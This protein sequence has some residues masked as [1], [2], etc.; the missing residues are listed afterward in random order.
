MDN[1]YAPRIGWASRGVTLIELL[2]VIAVIGMLVALMLPAVQAARESARKTTCAN[3]MRQMGLAANSYVVDQQVYP[4][5]WPKGDATVTWGHT[6]LPYLEQTSLFEAWD[7]DL[8]FFEGSNGDLAAT[9]VPVYKCP[10]APSPDIYLYEQPGYPSRMATIDYKSC[11]GA[12]ASDPLVKHWGRSGWV[13]GVISRHYTPPAAIRDGLS[14]TLM[15]VESVGGSVIYGPNRKPHEKVPQIWY[16]T[17]GSWVGRALSSVSPTNYATFMG[18]SDCT[19]NCSNMYDY[20]PY[21]FHPGGAHVVFCDGS[22]HFLTNDI[23]PVVILGLYS[24]DD[25]DLL[26][27]F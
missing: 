27:D 21:A 6:L 3:N 7:D 17:D 22:I 10:S 26:P 8:G 25:G 5:S 18:A 19:V 14:R 2:V 23:D 15:L 9:I 1:S 20:G 4:A 12:N 13:D 16:S 11:Q 24:Y